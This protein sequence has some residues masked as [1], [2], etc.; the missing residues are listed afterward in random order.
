MS[1]SDTFIQALK[2]YRDFSTDSHFILLYILT[3]ARQIAEGRLLLLQSD[4]S[5]L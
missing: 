1:P 5:G 2:A 4:F 3:M